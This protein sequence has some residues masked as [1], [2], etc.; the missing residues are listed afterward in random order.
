MET[1]RERLVSIGIATSVIR[2]LWDAAEIHPEAR[3]PLLPLTEDQR[4][5]LVQFAK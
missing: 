3:S 1:L 4:Q 5:V 2:A